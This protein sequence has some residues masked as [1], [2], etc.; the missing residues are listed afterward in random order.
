LYLNFKLDR[1][2]SNIEAIP[3][4][5][6]YLSSMFK[7]MDVLSESGSDPSTDEA[8]KRLAE[9]YGVVSPTQSGP[10]SQALPNPWAPAPKPQRS[11]LISFNFFSS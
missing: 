9:K 2:L 10:N 3:G 8:N 4:G 1:Q 6:N 5:F 11:P 7:D